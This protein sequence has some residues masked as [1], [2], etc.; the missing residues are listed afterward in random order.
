MKILQ[1]I[2]L[3]LML[4]GIVGSSAYRVAAD[5][6]TSREI[7]VHAQ[8]KTVSTAPASYSVDLLW[9]DMTFTYTRENTH[10]WN[11][12]DHS[13]ATRSS[14]GWDKTRA[15]ITV[16]NHSNVEV[17]VTITYTPV[18]DTG[19][20]GV[21]RNGTGTLD[22]G[23][24]GDYDGADSMTATLVI[25]GTPTDAVTDSKTRIGSLKVTIR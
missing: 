5:G 23:V 4:L 2:C 7:D 10:I 22:A 24:V 17:Q 15:S 18:E 12:K 11:A 6:G 19:I 14:G 25:S 8:Y 20:T 3:L 16:T 1:R 9:S 21:L 13:Y